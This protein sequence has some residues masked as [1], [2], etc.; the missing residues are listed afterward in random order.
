MNI[1]RRFASIEPKQKTAKPVAAKHESASE[2]VIRPKGRGGRKKSPT[3]EATLK[4]WEAAGVSRNTWYV[5]KRERRLFEEGV[6]AG[7]SEK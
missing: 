1:A 4:P 2:P 6:R 3:S 5:R 7:K